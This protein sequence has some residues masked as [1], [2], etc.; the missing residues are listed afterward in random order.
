M[1]DTTSPTAEARECQYCGG[2]YDEYLGFTMHANGCVT[3]SRPT[4]APDAETCGH[5]WKVE[6][7]GTSCLKCGAKLIDGDAVPTAAPDGAEVERVAKII[8]G[9]C[10]EGVQPEP[11]GGSL[12]TADLAAID[13]LSTP[14]AVSWEASTAEGGRP[15][16][17]LLTK[18]ETKDLLKQAEELWRDLKG[19][20]LGGY[21]GIN[22]PS[23]IVHQFRQ[24]IEQ[25][26]NRDT[27]LLWSKNQLDAAAPAASPPIERARVERLISAARP[28]AELASPINGEDGRPTYLEAI[29]GRD[30]TGELY[31]GSHFGTQK[32][33][34]MWTA[35][36]IELAAALRA[37]PVTRESG[38]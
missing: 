15:Y 21:S 8:R 23:W 14:P 3:L 17:Q 5:H 33:H 18:D 12:D 22:R 10:R 7:R 34:T 31:L 30:G 16:P 32:Q 37:L 29:E 28:F 19:N 25:F 27:G 38:K 36:F 13:I 35:D 4:A 6:R 11:F 24:V 26:G 1:T 2:E 20:N 9:Y